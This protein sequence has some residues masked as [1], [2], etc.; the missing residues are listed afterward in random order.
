M[1]AGSR[2]CLAPRERPAPPLD[3]HAA[4]VHRHGVAPFRPAAQGRRRS[5]LNRRATQGRH[6]S[7]SPPPTLPSSA[8]PYPLPPLRGPQGASASLSPWSSVPFEPVEA[9]NAQLHLVSFPCAALHLAPIPHGQSTFAIEAPPHT[10]PIGSSM[11]AM[12]NPPF[13]PSVGG[14]ARDGRCEI[15]RPAWGRGRAP[16]GLLMGLAAGGSAVWAGERAARPRPRGPSHGRPRGLAAGG[17]GAAWVGGHGGRGRRQNKNE[18]LFSTY[19][20]QW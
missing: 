13:F 4:A 10:P 5:P 14:G 12:S 1:A 19:V 11:M 2:T 20:W 16:S 17:G 18:S 8:P 3:S 9:A 6:C 15:R 7:P